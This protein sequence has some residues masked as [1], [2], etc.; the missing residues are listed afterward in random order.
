[1]SCPAREMTSLCL[2]FFH[3]PPNWL[4]H[5]QNIHM[6]CRTMSFKGF[7]AKTVFCSIRGCFVQVE[8]T[9]QQFSY[10]VK[11]GI[12]Y[13]IAY[14][15]VISQSYSGLLN[16]STSMQKVLNMYEDILTQGSSS[17]GFKGDIMM[18]FPQMGEFVFTADVMK[19]NVAELWNQQFLW[20]FFSLCPSSGSFFI[21]SCSR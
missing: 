5:C 16:S 2:D 9:H 3:L 19:E 12:F 15:W 1:M 11:P 10:V 17:A 20:Y 6:V 8:K 13:S 18:E 4:L 21:F 7:S 14:C